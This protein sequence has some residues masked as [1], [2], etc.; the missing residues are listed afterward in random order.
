ME[1][2]ELA[3]TAEHRGRFYTYFCPAG[4]P[5][6][7]PNMDGPAVCIGPSKRDYVVIQ[8]GG[9]MWCGYEAFIEH[10]RPLGPHL[11]DALFF[12]ADEEDYIDEFLIEG[13]RLKYQRV[14]QGAAWNL[15]RFL[16][17][18]YAMQDA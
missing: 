9:K 1:A 8:S 17:E 7:I 13:G 3:E 10:T 16:T 4:E 5:V 15:N 6:E 14:L 2:K 11:E 18:R 12:V